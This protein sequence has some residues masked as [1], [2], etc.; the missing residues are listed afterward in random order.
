MMRTGFVCLFL[1]A[2]RCLAFE[3]SVYL[4]SFDQVWTTVRDQYPDKE[5]AGIDW[6]GSRQELRPQVAQAQSRAEARSLLSK[7]LGRLPISHYAIIPE[8]AYTDFRNQANGDSGMEIRLIDQ[9]TVVTSVNSGGPADLAGIR[10]GDVIQAISGVSTTEVSRKAGSALDAYFRVYKHLRGPA[11]QKIPV[12]LGSGRTAEVMLALPAGK[13]IRFGNLPPVDASLATRRLEGPAG[14]VRP[15][16]FFDPENLA[17]TLESSLNDCA[18]CK[19]FVLDLRG[20]FGGMV[21]L[22]STVAGWFVAE[23]VSL[24]TYTTR[25]MTLKLAVNPRVNAFRGPLAILID[26]LSMSTSEFLAGGLKDLGRARLFGVTSA[27]AAVPSQ[28]QRLP[29]GDGFQYAFA[30]YRSAGGEVLEGKGVAPHVVVRPTRAG[31]LAGHDE[32]L[33]AAQQWILKEQKQ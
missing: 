6:E 26:E 30:S 31:L 5:M 23:P 7:L 11:G 25:E 14:Y 2:G 3:D 22:A 21:F 12:T 28:I 24:G 8:E 17:R 20:N 9:E 1:A 32:V 15:G 33:E 13:P 18:D 4:K 19:G 16:I 27:G 10:P 29:S